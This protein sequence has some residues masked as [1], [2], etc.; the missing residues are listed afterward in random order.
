[1]RLVGVLSNP[2][3]AATFGDY[4]HSLGISARVDKT[5]TQ[6][7]I[8]EIW[9]RDEDQ[10]TRS[11]N[12]LERF[13][14]NPKASEFLIVPAS[15]GKSAAVE[16]S[17]PVRARA[18][19]ADEGDH[20]PL[21]TIGLIFMCLLVAFAIPFDFKDEY[22]YLQQHGLRDRMLFEPS[23]QPAP[24]TALREGQLWRL[25]TPSL[26][27]GFWT[28][29]I[30]NM[31]M[32]FAY[33]TVVE[34]RVGSLVM[35]LLSL[36]ISGFSNSAQYSIGVYLNHPGPAHFLGMSGVVFGLF[37]YAWIRTYYA[38]PG[39]VWDGLVTSQQV[40]F[41]LIFALVCLTGVLGPVANTAHF[42]GLFAGMLW[43]WVGHLL[44]K[45]RAKG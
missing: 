6:P 38:R 14:A 30:M 2:E 22:E 34:R 23:G 36:F 44:Q 21:V 41:M 32:L 16:L 29:L 45:K 13:V 15:G 26:M 24:Y 31:M 43:A 19:A 25:F 3:L 8:W 4:L 11:K 27:H 42:G 20:S 18:T 9:V 28:H 37:G 17:P 33:G 39:D 35:L 5:N 10:V 40:Y 12:E 7:S 1:M